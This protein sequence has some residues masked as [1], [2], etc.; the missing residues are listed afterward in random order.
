MSDT[1]LPG[2]RIDTT[3]HGGDAHF[4]CTKTKLVIAGSFAFCILLTIATFRI[5]SALVDLAVER[6]ASRTSLEWA[7]FAISQ[8][9]QIADVAE[10]RPIKPE[11]W[12][13]FDKLAN[14]VGVFRFKIFSP[15]GVLRFVSD[16]PDARGENLGK[17]NHLAATVVSSGEPYTVVA[18]GTAKPDRPDL[19]S[20]TYLPVLH[21]GQI[22]AIAETYLDQTDKAA[23][24]RTEYAFVAVI[25]ISIIGLALSIPSAGLWFLFR[26]LKLNNAELKLSN[27]R[28]EASDKAKSEF[29]STVSH[30]LRTPLT[31]IKGSLEILTSGKIIEMK[32]PAHRLLALAAKNAGILNLLVNDLLDFGKLNTGNLEMKKQPSDL[33]KLIR[34][35]LET[36]E[37]YGANQ[38]IRY[39]FDGTDSP[40]PALVDP[41][42]IAQVVRNL[43]SNA[44]KFSPIGGT[45]EV[46]VTYGNGT[47]RIEVRDS[48]CGI[49]K[50]DQLIIFDRFTQVDSSNTRKHNGTGL[51]L[52]ISKQIVEAHGGEIG[53]VSVMGNGSLFYVNLP[54]GLENGNDPEQHLKVA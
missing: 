38:D 43:V 11:D 2:V 45:V 20:E 31:S 35:E 29:I 34:D 5:A 12:E 54:V 47:A 10:G 27:I 42:R 4:V 17:H 14:F 1:I 26:R 6:D 22:I 24:V 7:E 39:R 30:E 9:P 18:D 44:A 8:V 36:I 48:G 25:M 3:A 33:V 15:N 23:A 53:V 49:S 37:L 19:Y 51:G 52:A 46:S 50:A 32:G 28:A 41:D 13:A 40:Q 21:N 16:D